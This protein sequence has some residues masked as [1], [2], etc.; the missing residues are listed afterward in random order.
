MKYLA[1]ES[2]VR[3]ILLTF[4]MA[5]RLTASTAFVEG[6]VTS[7][8]AE[9]RLWTVTVIRSSRVRTSS[10]VPTA[11]LRTLIHIL[12][13]YIPGESSSGT[14]AGKAPR[15]DL[16][17]GNAAK[18]FRSLTDFVVSGTVAD[19]LGARTGAKVAAGGAVL[20]GRTRTGVD[21][22]LT[23]KTGKSLQTSAGERVHK[24][25]TGSVV[26]TRRRGAF[27]NVSFTVATYTDIW[28]DNIDRL[29]IRDVSRNAIYKSTIPTY[30]LTGK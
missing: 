14:V 2:F 26:E 9:T 27:V 11:T 29:R 28:M 25:N 10:A 1:K 8:P 24:V 21:R 18:A 7:C 13:T 19:D 3:C 23:T 12:V 17:V 5:D 16:A 30:L 4:I 6:D 15:T 20:A 22:R